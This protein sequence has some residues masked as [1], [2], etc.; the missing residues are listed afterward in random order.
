M[1][2]LFYR[3]KMW[4][5]INVQKIDYF[6]IGVFFCDALNIVEHYQPSEFIYLVWDI[7]FLVLFIFLKWRESR[8]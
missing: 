3:L 1:I 6:I 7:T 8:E 4:Y 5:M 2:D